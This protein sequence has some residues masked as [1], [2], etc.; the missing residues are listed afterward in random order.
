MLFDRLD[1]SL[2]ERLDSPDRLRLFSS[3]SSSPTNI[4]VAIGTSVEATVVIC[5]ATEVVG[6]IEVVG[7][8]GMLVVVVMILSSMEAVCGKK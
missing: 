7:V 3:L 4:V 6:F 8:C 5:S 1:R 2:F